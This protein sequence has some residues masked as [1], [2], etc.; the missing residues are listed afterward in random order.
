MRLRSRALSGIPG[1]ATSEPRTVSPSC[2]VELKI[3]N[4]EHSRRVHIRF[5][6]AD[7]RRPIICDKPLVQRGF[8]INKEASAGTSIIRGSVSVQGLTKKTGFLARMPSEFRTDGKMN[9]DKALI[10]VGM[11]RDSDSDTPM[12]IATDMPAP[13]PGPSAPRAL[14]SPVFPVRADREHRRQRTTHADPFT[15]SSLVFGM[16]RRQK[17]RR[18]PHRR[19]AHKDDDVLPRSLSITDSVGT[20]LGD[21][22]PVI[23]FDIGFETGPSVPCSAWTLVLEGRVQP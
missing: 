21:V 8:R 11:R 22:L 2:V 3:S 7:V 19:R 23:S 17:T 6:V 4:Q 12:D 10:A 20:K 1:C 9:I 5:A 15:V 14:P 13:L 18:S 16:R